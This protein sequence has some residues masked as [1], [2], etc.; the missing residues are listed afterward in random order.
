MVQSRDVVAKKK[1]RL[2]QY[3]VMDPEEDGGSVR[4]CCG[5]LKRCGGS[6]RRCCGPVKRCG[7]SVRRWGPWLS[8][9]MRCLCKEV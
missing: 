8:W 1:G 7:G 4:R 6:V 3:G 2:A 5:P 9:E